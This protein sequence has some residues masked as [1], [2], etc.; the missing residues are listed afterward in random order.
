[1]TITNP[2]NQGMYTYPYTGTGVTST[3]RTVTVR[4]YDKKGNMV[5]ETITVDEFPTY[6]NSWTTTNGTN[7][8]LG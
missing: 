1:M 3:K 6:G 2:V 4:E 7:I 5:K 8:K